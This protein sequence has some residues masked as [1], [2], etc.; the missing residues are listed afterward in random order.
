MHSICFSIISLA[1][2]TS[3]HEYQ[4]KECDIF[5]KMVDIWLSTKIH[6]AT[7][8]NIH[9]TWTQGVMLTICD[10]RQECRGREVA[11]EMMA[12]LVNKGGFWKILP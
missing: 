5:T 3:V 7:R 11:E 8:V 9:Q 4:H 1:C 10:K 6:S 12:L 2:T